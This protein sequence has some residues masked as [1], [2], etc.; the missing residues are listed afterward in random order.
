MNSLQRI[1]RL[2]A[3]V[4]ILALAASPVTSGDR[5]NEVCVVAGD[6]DY[7]APKDV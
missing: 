6:I 5:V 1:C 2:L 7:C 4:G 3:V